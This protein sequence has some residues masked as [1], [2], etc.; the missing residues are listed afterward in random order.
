M[1]KATKKI[2]QCEGNE[3]GWGMCVGSV[4]FHIGC[5]RKPLHLE[6]VWERLQNMWWERFSGAGKP[7]QCPWHDHVVGSFREQQGGW[8]G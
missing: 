5:K 2:K 1:I 4:L 8:T 7:V 3:A 6:K